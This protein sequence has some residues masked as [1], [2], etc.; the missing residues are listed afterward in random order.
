MLLFI[1]IYSCTTNWNYSTRTGI[2]ELETGINSETQFSSLIVPNLEITDDFFYQRIILKDR[3]KKIIHKNYT[4]FIHEN[5]V[6]IQ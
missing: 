4:H 6:Q 1:I 5:I 2:K 3:N